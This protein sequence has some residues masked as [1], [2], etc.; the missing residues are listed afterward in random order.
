VRGRRLGRAGAALDPGA[1][2]SRAISGAEDGPRPS[3]DLLEGLAI[4][5][6]YDY[7]LEG[8]NETLLEIRPDIDWAAWEAEVACYERAASTDADSPLLRHAL[9]ALLEPLAVVGDWGRFAQAWQRCGAQRMASWRLALQEWW[10]QKGSLETEAAQAAAERAKR[11]F[12]AKSG[13]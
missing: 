13:S 1:R 8:L 2:L 9:A 5:A 11:L 6:S 3:A 7:R 4:H 12:G 10:V